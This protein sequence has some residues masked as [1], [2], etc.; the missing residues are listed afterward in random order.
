MTFPIALLVLSG[1]QALGLI[2][3]MF[4]IAALPHEKGEHDCE[5]SGE[6]L[7]EYI[8]WK[9]FYVNP[10]DPRG[11][12]P[13]ASGVGWGVNF[14]KK[15]YVTIFVGMIVNALLLVVVG[16]SLLFAQL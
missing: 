11:M 16:L 3:F 12:I 1:I 15:S 5:P 14:R 4:R 7:M 2:I 13:R 10:N 6:Q 9:C 8:V